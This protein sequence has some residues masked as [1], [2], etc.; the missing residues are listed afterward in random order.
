MDYTDGTIKFNVIN[1][2]LGVLPGTILAFSGEFDTDGY[3]IDKLTGFADKGWHLCDGTN[4]TPDLRGRFILG[5]SDAHPVGS[6]GGEEAHTLTWDEG[7]P[8]SHNCKIYTDNNDSA[9]METNGVRL[10]SPNYV[11]AGNTTAGSSGGD[12]CGVT[13]IA[14]GGKPHNN[15]PPFYTLSYIMF[16]G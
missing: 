3:P 15:M 16:I 7:F 1:N 4:G 6:V 14:G 12:L 10:H 13:E 8:H 2:K 5:N 9:K 11:Y